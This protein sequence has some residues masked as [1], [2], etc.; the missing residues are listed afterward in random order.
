MFEEIPYYGVDYK[1]KDIKVL[2]NGQYKVTRYKDSGEKTYTRR[3]K[4][5]EGIEMINEEYKNTLNECLDKTRYEYHRASNYEYENIDMNRNRKLMIGGIIGLVIPFFFFNS[6]LIVFVG[7]PV[8]FISV[9]ILSAVGEN[10][11]IN[12]RQERFR[13][14]K[15]LHDKYDTHNEADKEAI[16][17]TYYQEI[18]PTKKEETKQKNHTRHLSR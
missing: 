8:A 1:I 12:K 7:T 4:S 9:M 2:D 18:L 17:K 6:M 13:Q 14:I 16:T 3:V 11:R 15:K 10:F 5:N